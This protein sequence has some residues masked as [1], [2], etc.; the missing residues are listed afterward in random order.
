M[1]KKWFE[2]EMH[3]FWCATILV[4]VADALV[5]WVAF[6]VNPLEIKYAK[7][8][9]ILVCSVMFAVIYHWL[10][11][12]HKRHDINAV[13]DDMPLYIYL[14]AAGAALCVD[15]AVVSM[16]F[17]ITISVFI[18]M[19]IL[20]YLQDVYC[21]D[22]HTLFESIQKEVIAFCKSQQEHQGGV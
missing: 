4:I 7:G 8:F 17:F 3:R 21:P 20:R 10:D 19:N 16:V 9:V 11:M 15:F 18:W 22:D 5:L 2:T 12:Q 13:N 1:S 14:L 6:Y